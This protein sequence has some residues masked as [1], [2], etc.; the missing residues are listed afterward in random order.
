MPCPVF[1]Y[2]ALAVRNSLDGELRF[3]FN[4]KLVKLLGVGNENTRL[5]NKDSVE[6]FMLSLLGRLPEKN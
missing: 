1:Q 3:C 4:G 6:I 5:F 2:Y